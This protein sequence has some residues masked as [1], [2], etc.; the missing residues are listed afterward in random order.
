MKSQQQKDLD[1]IFNAATTKS[2][3]NMDVVIQT[4]NSFMGLS[5]TV[6]ERSIS[7]PKCALKKYVPQT[8]FERELYSQTKQSEV[9][10]L[11]LLKQVDP[12][13]ANMD[14]ESFA[15]MLEDKLHEIYETELSYFSWKQF[16]GNLRCL[17]LSAFNEEKYSQENLQLAYDTLLRLLNSWFY[18]EEGEQHG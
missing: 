12:L 2:N 3:N 17:L 18:D 10:N 16:Q 6:Y 8:H 9:L 11:K 4:Y 15:E 1:I 13:L 14:D 7:C 5:D